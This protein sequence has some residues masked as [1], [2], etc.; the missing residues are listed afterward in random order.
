MKGRILTH[1]SLR[2][3]PEGYSSPL[4]ICFVQTAKGTFL[5]YSPKNSKVRI[6][7]R[8]TLKKQ[9]KHYYA[10]ERKFLGLI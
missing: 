7:Q 6:G 5:A 2:V 3:V 4:D 9:G 10:A 1:T 8:V